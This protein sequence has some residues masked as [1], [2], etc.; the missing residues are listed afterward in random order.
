MEGW[1]PGQGSWGPELANMWRTGNDIWPRWEKCILHNL[2]SNNIA[3]DYQRPG[4]FNECDQPRPHPVSP[5]LS[6]CQSAFITCP[7]DL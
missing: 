3:A 5:I 6:A 7:L 4:A 1:S 2:Y